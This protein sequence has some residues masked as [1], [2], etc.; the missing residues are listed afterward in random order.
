MRDGRTSTRGCQSP[1]YAWHRFSRRQYVHYCFNHIQIRANWLKWYWQS[2]SKETAYGCAAPQQ[3]GAP[4]HHIREENLLGDQRRQ[5]RGALDHRVVANVVQHGHEQHLRVCL[6]PLR[7]GVG[8][9][10][11]DLLGLGVGSGEAAGAGKAQLDDF[12]HLAERLRKKKG[13][14]PWVTAREMRTNRTRACC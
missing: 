12:N 14:K 9:V 6:D 11:L 5:G 2:E 10:R 13:G 3:P 7:Q 8:L 1:D 4:S